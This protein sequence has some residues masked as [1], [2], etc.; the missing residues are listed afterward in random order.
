MSETLESISESLKYFGA[1]DYAVFILMLVVCSCVGLF[2]GYKDHRK[3]KANKS[4]SRRGSQTL[5]YLLGGKNVQVFPGTSCACL[6]YLRLKVSFSSCDVSCGFVCFRDHVVRYKHRD[7]SL[8]HPIRVHFRLPD[9]DGHFYALHYHS[10]V[11]R[12]QSCQ[13]V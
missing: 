5:D 7:L 4:E 2:F 1:L 9:C 8:R 3:H 10:R 11:L 13:H 6:N 12:P